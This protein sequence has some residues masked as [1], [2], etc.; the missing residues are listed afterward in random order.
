MFLKRLDH[1][2]RDGD[3][4]RAIIRGWASNNDGRGSPPMCPGT[5]SQAACIRAA[6][7][8]ANLQDFETTAYIECHGMDTAVRIAF[9]F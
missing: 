3:P 6:Y 8:M 2:L 4:I 1:A 7:A 9:W 5:D